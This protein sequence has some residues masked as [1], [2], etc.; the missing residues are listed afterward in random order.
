MLSNL[1][2]LD[3]NLNNM[4]RTRTVKV[5]ELVDD[6]F[7]DPTIRRK[8]AEGRLPDTW[9]EVAGP[10]VASCTDAVTYKN[11]IMTVK[12]TSSVVRHEVFMQRT[13]LRDQIN[14]RSGAVLVRELIVK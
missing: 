13:F 10:M 5:G 7:R 4:R 8:I 2:S 6:L 14:V 12:I 1:N 11:G 3:L 9:A